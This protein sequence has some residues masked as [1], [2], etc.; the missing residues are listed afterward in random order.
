[1]SFRLI[2]KNDEE[3]W[4]LEHKGNPI[5]SGSLEAVASL[6]IN[7]YDFNLQE[8]YKAL[9]VIEKTNDNCADFGMWKSFMYTTFERNPALVGLVGSA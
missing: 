1:M 2:Q 7:S 3:T 6:M 8:I 5:Y 9:D 4:V